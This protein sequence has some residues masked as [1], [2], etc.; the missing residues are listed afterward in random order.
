LPTNPNGPAQ[1]RFGFKLGGIAVY[2]LD[3]DGDISNGRA[4]YRIDE[5]GIDGMT[6]DT[7]GNLYAARHNGNR[8]EPKGSVVVLS[9]DGKVIQQ[10]VLPEPMIATNLGFGRGADAHLL[11]MTAAYTWRLYR[12]AT[13][14]RGH[15]FD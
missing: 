11:Y 15:Y 9:P 10:L 3:G 14:Q 12:I 4:F 8:S 6:M 1:D 7:A 2:D 5:F 13:T